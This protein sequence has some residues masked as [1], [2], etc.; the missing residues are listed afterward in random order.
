MRV[1]SGIETGVI[2]DGANGTNDW[3]NL[4]VIELLSSKFNLYITPT[5]QMSMNF[6]HDYVYYGD[7]HVSEHDFETVEALADDMITLANDKVSDKNV[8][9]TW[10]EGDFWLLDHNNNFC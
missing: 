6:V 7:M 4:R 3:N 10:L 1:V 8:L 9:F 5:D 2:F